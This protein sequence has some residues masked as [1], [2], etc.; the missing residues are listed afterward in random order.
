MMKKTILLAMTVLGLVGCSDEEK[1]Y[2]SLTEE[3]IEATY[4]PGSYSMHIEANCDWEASSDVG[5][6]TFNES[7]GTGTAELTFNV[8]ANNEYMQRTAII[9]IT[10]T[11]GS[12]KTG[13]QLT[14][15]EKS[16]VTLG[17]TPAHV[18]APAEGGLVIIKFRTNVTYQVSGMEDWLSYLGFTKN[19]VPATETGIDRYMDTHMV[20][21]IAY[22]N[23]TGESRIC[24]IVIEG[25]EDRLYYNIVQPSMEIQAQSISFQH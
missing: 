23:N 6:V 20:E 10:A 22:P 24:I 9:S 17:E 4:T 7:T 2:I 16:G 21:F 5:W 8:D 1:A 14:Q 12:A 25:G 11:N 15:R 19:G 18:D 13:L 3:T